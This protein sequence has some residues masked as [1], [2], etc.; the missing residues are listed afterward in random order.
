MRTFFKVHDFNN[1]GYIRQE[2]LVGIIRS[3]AGAL[4]A[5]PETREKLVED[6]SKVGYLFYFDYHN[7]GLVQYLRNR[8]FI[9]FYIL[10]K[11]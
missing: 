9:N 3:L 4:N 1:A 8:I 5:A 11:Q 6:M 7:S 10:N 2:G